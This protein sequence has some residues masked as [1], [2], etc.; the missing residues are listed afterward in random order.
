MKRS[1]PIE[2]K[3]K[4]AMADRFHLIL[5]PLLQFGSEQGAEDPHDGLA[6]FGPSG[7]AAQL[8]DHIAIGTAEG[9]EREADPRASRQ[10]SAGRIIVFHH[11]GVC[12]GKKFAPCRIAPAQ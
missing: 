4:K 9:L 12:A 5:E 2:R 7:S 11:S 8:P 1:Q 6:L 3:N 10:R